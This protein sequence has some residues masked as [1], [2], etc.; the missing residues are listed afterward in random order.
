MVTGKASQR[1]FSPS[2]PR[3]CCT[4]PCIRKRKEKKKTIG[5]KLWVLST[6]RY[7][8]QPLLTWWKCIIVV[9]RPHA[10]NVKIAREATMGGTHPCRMIEN[11][12]KDCNCRLF[13]RTSICSLETQ[14]W[15]V[16]VPGFVFYWLNYAHIGIKRHLLAPIGGSYFAL[17]T[18][19]LLKKKTNGKLGNL[20]LSI[21][22][23]TEIGHRKKFK[24]WRFGR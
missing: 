18:C 15:D 2:S 17:S 12:M 5:E 20:V 22:L 11:R 16:S 1:N 10:I 3:H 9:F 21:E 8:T 14:T 13:S 4:W 24:S 23:I 6:F 19:L 7:I